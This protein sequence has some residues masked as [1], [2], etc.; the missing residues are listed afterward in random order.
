MALTILEQRILDQE[1]I[2]W[3]DRDA[4]DLESLW[5]QPGMAE[6]CPPGV[7]PDSYLEHLKELSQ[8]IECGEPVDPEELKVGLDYDWKDR[9]FQRSQHLMN[10]IFL[11]EDWETTLEERERQAGR[12]L[13]ERQEQQR[14]ITRLKALRDLREM[15]DEPESLD[16]NRNM[17]RLESLLMEYGS[18]SG[19]ES[20]LAALEIA[21][22][23]KQ[24][25]TD[26]P[27]IAQTGIDPEAESSATVEDGRT[28]IDP[29]TG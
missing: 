27:T 5:E 28:T 29:P 25:I 3:L 13:P 17:W 10:Q 12:P 22:A 21:E 11:A 23:Q 24:G 18:Q 16:V 20:Q 6:S 7:M 8:L 9:Q 26:L 2:D 19:W 4:S 15:L 1:V 14:A